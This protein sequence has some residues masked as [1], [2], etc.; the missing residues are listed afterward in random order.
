[1]V[2]GY[3]MDKHTSKN[4][5]PSGNVLF[6]HSFLDEYGLD[7][8]EFRTYSHVVRRS[9]GKGNVAFFAKL[10]TTSKLLSMSVRKLQ[11]CLKLLCALRLLRKESRPGR[12]DQYFVTPPKTWVVNTE[13]DL[14]RARM[15]E[16][17]SSLDEEWLQKLPSY[18]EPRLL[19]HQ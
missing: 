14:V 17:G 18:E 12:T 7:P 16:T 2:H 8:Y 13:I 4:D 5:M 10:S 11:G 19:P 3:I 6:L 1:M 9:G 15:K